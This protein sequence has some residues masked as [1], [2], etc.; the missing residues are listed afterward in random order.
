M[1]DQRFVGQA[2]KVLPHGLAAEGRGRQRSHEFSCGGGHD[3]AHRGAVLAKPPDHLERLVCGD[4]AA[5]D[6]KNARGGKRTD[7]HRPLPATPP[8]SSPRIVRTI[9][10]EGFYSR[11]RPNA[12]DKSPRT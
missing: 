3:D 7:C 2:E 6:E 12:T 8:P 4:P 11:Q 5:D 10:T 9:D 1:A